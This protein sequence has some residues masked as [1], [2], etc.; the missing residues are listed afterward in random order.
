MRD[1]MARIPLV[2]GKLA[3]AVMAHTVETR[4]GALRCWTYET[5]GFAA[6]AQPELRFSLLRPEGARDA[7]YPED[8]L[9]L[10]RAMWSQV[11]RGARFATGDVTEFDGEGLLGRAALRGVMWL[12]SA[13]ANEANDAAPRL[14]ALLLLEDELETVRALGPGRV[15]SRLAEASGHYPYPFWN[16]A[17]RGSV[18]RGESLSASPRYDLF[19]ATVVGGTV[20]LAGQILNL[21]LPRAGREALADALSQLRDDEPFSLQ[22]APTGVEPAMLVWHPGQGDARAISA[23]DAD[24]EVIYGHFLVMVAQ[25]GTQ[26]CNVFEDGFA[27]R[28]ST[29]VL[30]HLRKALMQGDNFEIGPVGEGE[31]LG[32]ALSWS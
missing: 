12:P 1:E 17:S 8:P 20:S 22:F 13:L 29:H 10:F 26:G 30:S 16:V 21:R 28:S 25:G 32:L 18:L 24:G 6:R 7:E 3:A 31:R 2:M 19:R 11:E 14:D 4:E 5:D 27:F 9:H 23:A 15:L